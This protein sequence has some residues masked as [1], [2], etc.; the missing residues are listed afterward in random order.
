VFP[1]LGNYAVL[2]YLSLMQ[3][4]II[5]FTIGIAGGMLGALFGVGGGVIMVPALLKFTDLDMKESVA[6]S[7]AIIIITSACATYGNASAN[8]IN[9]KLVAIAGFGAALAAYF[10]SGAM[11]EMNNETL[12][13][14]FAVLMIVMGVYLLLPKGKSADEAKPIVEVSNSTEQG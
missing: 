3:L 4:F 13:R 8:L 10:G 11:R 2:F 14:S 7:L 12:T 6:T 9:W 5:V 1:K